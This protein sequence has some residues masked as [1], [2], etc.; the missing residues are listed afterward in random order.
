MRDGRI[1]KGPM[2]EPTGCRISLK[3]LPEPG[4]LMPAHSGISQVKTLLPLAS[5]PSL[6]LFR[7]DWE[8]LL[9]R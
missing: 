2:Q 9:A 7:K 5:P 4:S 8:P 6:T 3:H 1:T